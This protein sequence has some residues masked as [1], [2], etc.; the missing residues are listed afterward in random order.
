VASVI[1]SY[2]LVL[3]ALRITVGVGRRQAL[4]VEADLGYGRF[5][6]PIRHRR[7]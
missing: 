3:E 5:V 1:L 4:R 6:L 7:S 2:P